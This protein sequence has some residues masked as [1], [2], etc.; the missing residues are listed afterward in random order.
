MHTNKQPPIYTDSDTSEVVAIDNKINQ[1]D[2]IDTSTSPFVH[3]QDEDDE[4]EYGY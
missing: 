3:W 4:H 1:Y 2:L